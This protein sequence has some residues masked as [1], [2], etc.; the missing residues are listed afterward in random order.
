MV[1]RHTSNSEGAGQLVVSG[2]EEPSLVFLLGTGTRIR[3]PRQ[4]RE[5]M[6]DPSVRL[7]L[8]SESVGSRFHEEVRR[9][10]VSVRS[11]DRIRGFNYSKGNRVALTLYAISR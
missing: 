2:Y 9:A 1:T 6:R 8:I 7:A 5:T 4:L 11:L 10:N 3:K